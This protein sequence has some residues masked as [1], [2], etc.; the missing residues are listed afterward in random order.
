MRARARLFGVA[1]AADVEALL[2]LIV[3]IMFVVYLAGEACLD[4]AVQREPLVVA[5]LQARAQNSL[6]GA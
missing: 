1:V 5:T 4:A 2:N 6:D 3:I